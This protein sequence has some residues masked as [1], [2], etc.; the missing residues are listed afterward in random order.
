MNISKLPLIVLAIAVIGCSS[1]KLVK[2]P[3]SLGTTPSAQDYYYC[4][5]CPAPSKLT[6]GSYKPLEPDDAVI[7]IIPVVEPTIIKHTKK[8]SHK[9]PQRKHK[10]I[11]KLNQPKQCIQ[12]RN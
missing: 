8:R 6:K 12:W 11:K 10:K 2:V 3:N 7:T 1:D 5:S 9:K 4:E